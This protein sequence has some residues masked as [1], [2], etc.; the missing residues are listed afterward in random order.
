MAS[1]KIA[2]R[3][4]SK[5]NKRILVLEINLNVYASPMLKNILFKAICWIAV[6]AFAGIVKAQDV[7]RSVNGIDVSVHAGIEE[8]TL[9]PENSQ[10]SVKKQTTFASWTPG[11]EKQSSSTS[12]QLPGVTAT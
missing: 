6:V 11:R 1:Y 8:E 4:T 5:S 9:Q 7:D 2:A 12:A 3:P 10:K